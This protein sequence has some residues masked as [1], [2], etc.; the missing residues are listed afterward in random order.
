MLPISVILR[1]TSLDWTI[2]TGNI[3]N[4]GKLK[5]KKTILN[6]FRAFR[7]RFFLDFPHFLT[8][9][10]SHSDNKTILRSVR[11]HYEEACLSIMETDRCKF[12]L[13]T[14]VE[15][16]KEKLRNLIAKAL[17]LDRSW[18]H[19][20]IQTGETEGYRL[21]Q[22]AAFLVKR[23][24]YNHNRSLAAGNCSSETDFDSR[25]HSVQMTKLDSHPTY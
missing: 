17:Q 24:I 14:C 11:I 22:S 25:D 10:Y 23:K 18:W 15:T 3:A 19:G 12:V 8:W 13:Q 7:G 2:R 21:W 9:R 20:N 6:D 16:I 4:P 5:K 1:Q